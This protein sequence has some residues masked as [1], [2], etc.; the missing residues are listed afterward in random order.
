M[1]GRGDVCIAMCNADGYYTMQFKGIKSQ[2]YLCLIF[3]TFPFKLKT[4]FFPKLF[5]ALALY[6][7]A[8]SKL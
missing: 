6:N 2:R 1:R 5:T 8:R 3:E 4:N 7:V